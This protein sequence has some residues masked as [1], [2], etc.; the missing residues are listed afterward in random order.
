MT[1]AP[2][3]RVVYW[4]YGSALYYLSERR[5]ATRFPYVTYLTGA[6]EGTPYWWSPFHPSQPLE[7]PRA[8]DLFFEDLERHPPALFV[9]TAEPGYFGFYKFP[10]A[11]YPRLQE[12]LEAPASGATDNSIRRCARFE[13]SMSSA[14]VEMSQKASPVSAARVKLAIAT[15]SSGG[16]SYAA[17]FLAA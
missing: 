15:E 6:V 11:R 8:W 16:E 1:T 10:P 2:S 13:R 4:G 14:V 7:I 12:Y 17:E 5:P 3:D 9:D